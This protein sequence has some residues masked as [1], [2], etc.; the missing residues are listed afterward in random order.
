GYNPV[1]N[2]EVTITNSNGTANFV[3]APFSG[4]LFTVS[5]TV[6][7]PG[8]GTIAGGG[9]FPQNSTVTMTATPVSVPPYVFVNWTENGYFQSASSNYSFTLTRNRQLA[10]NFTLPLYSLAATNNPPGAGTVAGTGS[11]FYGTTNV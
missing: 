3:A 2:Q 5:G 7:P 11:F 10:A 6:N 9:T 4:Q 8:A 1:A